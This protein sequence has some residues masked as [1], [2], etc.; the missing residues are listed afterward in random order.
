MFILIYMSLFCGRINYILPC[1]FF[2]LKYIVR[3]DPALLQ[4]GYKHISRS[5]VI[6]NDSS[7]LNA[8]NDYHKAISFSFSE[9]TFPFSV[10][11]EHIF[12]A[13]Y[14][15]FRNKVRQINKVGVGL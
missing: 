5:S 9:N 1:L 12:L 15:L 14:N 3:L 10:F 8:C 7:G 6:C 13:R 2:L 4:V 11:C